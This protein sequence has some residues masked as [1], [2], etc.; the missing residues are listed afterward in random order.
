[1]SPAWRRWISPRPS[2]TQLAI[3]TAVRFLAQRPRS[4]YEVR[5]RLRRASVDEA[6]IEAVL[7]QLHE[8]RLLDDTAFAQYWVE[9]RQ[10]FR[11]RGARL[12][13]AELG[14]LGVSTAVAGEATSEAASSAEEDAYRAAARRAAQLRHLGHEVFA[15]RLSAFLAR[16]G[17]DWAVSAS[18]VRRLWAEV[19]VD[20]TAT[21]EPES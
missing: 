4:A 14:R 16:R 8:Y 15:A 11:P 2:D 13:R 6:V 5:Q 1:M 20:E 7:A 21:L 17:F 19:S 18:V 9:Q 10:T 3:D 12:L